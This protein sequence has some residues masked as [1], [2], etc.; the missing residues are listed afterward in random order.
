MIFRDDLAQ[1][2]LFMLHM[3]PMSLPPCIY[4]AGKYSLEIPAARFQSSLKPSTF[5]SSNCIYLLQVI[6]YAI[7]AA[8][9]CLT[10]SWHCITICIGNSKFLYL[11]AAAAAIIYNNS[12]NKQH[13]QFSSSVADLFRPRPNTLTL[14]YSSPC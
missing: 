3:Q 12:Y 1:S 10:Y 8:A 14:S 11:H 9:V 7:C 4:M 6:S 5:P 13:Q 2:D